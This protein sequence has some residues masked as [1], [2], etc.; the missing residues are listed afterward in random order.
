MTER[1]LAA[2]RARVARIAAKR[3]PRELVIEV[4]CE[5]EPGAE[6]ELLDLLL[7]LLDRF[8]QSGAP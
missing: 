7:D 3:P 4:R 1:G 5:P 6:D 8:E 2:R